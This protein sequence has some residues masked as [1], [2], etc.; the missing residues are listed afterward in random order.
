MG[1]LHLQH[2]DDAARDEEDQSPGLRRG[3]GPEP[4]LPRRRGPGEGAAG[5]VEP[6]AAHPHPRLQGQGARPR[7]AAG[8]GLRPRRHRPRS[9]TAR[10]WRTA[11]TTVRSAWR[12][13]G[14]ASTKLAQGSRDRGRKLRLHERLPEEVWAQARGS[15]IKRKEDNMPKETHEPDLLIGI[16]S[17]RADHMSLYGY[18]RLTTP[19]MDK[20]AARR[21]G[22]RERA[23]ARTF[24]PRPA[25]PPCSPA[26]TASARTWWR[27]ATRAGLAA[28][29]TTLAEMLGEEGYDTTC[30]GFSGNPASR[31]FQKY[32]DFAGW[33]SWEEGRSPK[34]ENLNAV[35]HPGAE[36]PGRRAS[37]P[38]FLFLRHMD[39]HS[40]YLPPRPFERMFYGG[41]EFDPQNHS[42]DPVYDVQ[43]VLRLLRELVPA[44]LHGQGLHH[45]PVRR[46][47]WPTWTPASP[48]S[49]PRM[50]ALGLEEDTL[51]VIDSDHGETLYDHD[52]YFDHHGL[53][54]CTL[55]IPLVFVYAGQG[56][57]RQA[58]QRT[59]AR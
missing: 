7:R 31:G 1:A 37:K 13:S 49:S 16:D 41:D 2:A 51:V 39:P 19:H 8:P 23:S 36:A 4:H 17:L 29:S 30:V 38:F 27:C 47:A 56:A 6:R 55:R 11:T 43:A 34:A 28:T 22:V 21:R 57:G 5:G 59:S 54:E 14:R 12:S 45:R 48:T 50:Q 46:R 25:T 33:G 26:W 53:Y 44:G 10:R 20:F 18:P 24:R 32:M 52:C 35:A 42:L 3:H 40:P 15:R 9:A 58:L